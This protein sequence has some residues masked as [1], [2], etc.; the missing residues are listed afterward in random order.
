MKKVPFT[1]E[2]II[3]EYYK[4]GSSYKAAEALGI[5][6]QVVLRRLKKYGKEADAWH[7]TQI[8]I[9]YSKQ[10]E[11]LPKHPSVDW[12]SYAIMEKYG[13]VGPCM[14]VTCP[15]CKEDRWIALRTICH[16]VSKPWY[17]GACKPCWTS[18]PKPRLFRSKRNPKGRRVSNQGYVV[19]TQNAI[20][21]EDM[22]LFDLCKTK[23]NQS[24]YEHRWV[25]AKHLKRPLNSNELVDH[26]DG[27]R[28]N[29]D[30]SN[31]RIYIRGE[32]QE[33]SAP[34]YGTYYHEWQ[35]ALAIIQILETRKISISSGVAKASSSASCPIQVNY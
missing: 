16:Q 34:G 26:R 35:T 32:N 1:D 18:L 27:N 20:S 6:S 10:L 23:N 33:G 14:K 2:E 15:H 22:P 31:L 13:H 7:S 25:M 5:S 4:T 24:I 19:L 17:T 8:P 28:Q 3:A 29:N 9:R 11:K 30:L 21:M 12:N